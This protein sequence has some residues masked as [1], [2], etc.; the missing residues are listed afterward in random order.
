MMPVQ[1]GDSILNISLSISLSGCWV[2][3]ARLVVSLA[4][5]CHCQID[6]ND[7]DVEFIATKTTVSS[8]DGVGAATSSKM[9]TPSF[10]LPFCVFVVVVIVVCAFVDGVLPCGPSLYL[11]LA[12]VLL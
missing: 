8:A 7:V 11:T 6:V 9:S 3:V 2:Q 1:V 4:E 10:S 12:D 5:C